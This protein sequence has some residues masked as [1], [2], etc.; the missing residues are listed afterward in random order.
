M[1][2]LIESRFQN[3]TEKISMCCAEVVRID[4]GESTFLSSVKMDGGHEPSVFC[5]EVSHSLTT[6][7]FKAHVDFF[8]GGDGILCL[9]M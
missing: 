1:G 3:M 8:W 2:M 4:N 6:C 9:Y 7:K 5:G